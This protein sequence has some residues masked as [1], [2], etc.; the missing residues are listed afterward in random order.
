[1]KYLI[2]F[3]IVLLVVDLH[4]QP[5]TDQQYNA[6]IRLAVASSNSILGTN[7]SW[8]VGGSLLI[9]SE[10]ISVNLQAR[11][12]K[13]IVGLKVFPNPTKDKLFIYY[14]NKGKNQSLEF[15]VGL[16]DLNGKELLN[17]SILNNLMEIDLLVLPSA[18]YLIKVFNSNDETLKTY[19]I[20]KN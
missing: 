14:Q 15:R 18:V 9:F 7:T 2:T 20:I 6:N 4:A 1:M 19:K 10:E 3:L 13:Q 12:A 17:R 16:F 5:N 11:L 8:I